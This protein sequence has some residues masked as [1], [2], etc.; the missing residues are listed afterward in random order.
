VAGVVGLA[1]FLRLWSAL[2]LPVDFDEP[3]YLEAAYDYAAALRAGDFNAIIDYPENREH[4]PLV[5]LVYG[6][7]LAALGEDP[8]F[9]DALFASRIVSAVFG[10]LA[11]LLVA[12]VSPL[13]GGMLAVHTLAVKYTSQAYLEALPHFTSVAAILAFWRFS[14]PAGDK[15][16]PAGQVFSLPSS[17]WFW[18]SA[19]A[20]GLT[21]AGKYAYFPVVAVIVFLA[22]RSKRSD[23]SLWALLPYFAAAVLVF[24]A[25]NPTLWREPVGRFLESLTFHSQF[26]QSAHVQASGYGWYQPILWIAHSAAFQW[27]PDIIFYMGFDGLIFWLAVGGLRREWSTRPWLLVWLGFSLLVL[28]AW[29]TKWPQYTLVL[30]PALCLVAAA[31]LKRLYN[32]AAEYESYYGTL[33]E[34]V[35]RPPLSVW[36]MVIGIGTFLFVGYIAHNVSLARSRVGWSQ[37]TPVNSFLPSGVVYDLLPGRDGEMLL[38]TDRG[39]A[40]WAPPAG[41]DLPDSWTIYT[42]ENSGLPDNRVLAMA[43]DP[44]G[45]LWVGTLAGAARFEAGSWSVYRGQDMNLQSEQI[46][47]LAEGSR[48]ELWVGTSAGAAVFDGQIWQAFTTQTSGLVNDAVFS[49]AVE[50]L[51]AG[52]RVWFGTLDGLSR[53]DTSSGVWTSYTRADFDMPRA[54]IADLKFAPDGGLWMATLG[55]GLYRIDEEGW[56]VYRTSNSDIPYNTLQTVAISSRGQV[57]IGAAIPNATGGVVA[58]QDGLSWKTF[59][60]RNSGYTEAEPVSLAFDTN[61]RVW[62]A[63]RSNGVVIY[64]STP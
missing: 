7:T 54:G 6:L 14:R 34:M 56:Q 20:L 44:Q 62:I 19:L 43:G 25:F 12:L 28:L 9:T 48:G 8:S 59:I 31:T 57:W 10:T 17:P 49:L 52:D 18:L 33:S 64:Q 46:N 41:S 2:Q 3:V 21:L 45:T 38:G 27:H 5:K 53:L 32:W 29:P 22:L 26:A 24:W 58:V 16:P 13:A 42:R 47:T 60:G 35:P 4:P 30:V 61:D 51:P 36:V 55:G 50:P 15:P 23:F 40:V 37:L 11:V 1:L 63:T 39:L